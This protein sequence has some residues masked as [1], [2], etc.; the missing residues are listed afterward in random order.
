[1]KFRFIITISFLLLMSSAIYSQD[2]V[3]STVIEKVDGKDYYI[4]LLMKVS[5]WKIASAYGLTTNDIILNNPE[6]KKKIKPG[7]KLKIPIKGGQ[8][9]I[10]P[11]TTNHIVEKGESLYSIAKSYSVTVDDIKK[12]NPG[13]TEN[14]KPGQTIIIPVKNT[15]SVKNKNNSD[16]LLR[17]IMHPVIIATTLNFLT[18]T[19]S[20]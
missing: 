2:V 7:Q 3:K 18:I 14:L 6:A 4:V 9:I 16:K 10:A 8:N 15:T 17:I 12:V 13:L 20:H 5:I 1:M 11:T 19:I